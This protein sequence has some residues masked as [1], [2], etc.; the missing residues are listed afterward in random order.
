MRAHTHPGQINAQTYSPKHTTGKNKQDRT[1]D[2]GGEIRF[3]G[4]RGA[5]Q[6]KVNADV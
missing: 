1:G 4:M 2:K 5:R 6:E 3:V